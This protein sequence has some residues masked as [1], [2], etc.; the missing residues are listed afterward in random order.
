[1]STIQTKYYERSSKI[2]DTFPLKHYYLSTNQSDLSKPFAIGI[3]S[4]VNNCAFCELQLVYE[5]GYLIDFTVNNLYYFEDEIKNFLCVDDK[6]YFLAEKYFDLF[7]DKPICKT[8]FELLPLNAIKNAETLKGVL[9]AQKTTDI[10]SFI[11]RCLK[12]S[13]TA[14][15]PKTIKYTLTG[16]GNAT[17]EEMQKAAFRITG[18]KYPEFLIN[19]HLADSFAMAFHYWVTKLK[20]EIQLYHSPISAQYAY[21]T[22]LWN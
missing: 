3:D 2:P 8:T 16:N 14:V 20:E 18:N 15:S 21:M 22:W 6:Y 9:R 19:D 10:I 13:Y 7:K 5:N 11:C 1:M 4:G 17:K 12:H